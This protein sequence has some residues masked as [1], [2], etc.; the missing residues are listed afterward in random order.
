MAHNFE[1]LAKLLLN[2]WWI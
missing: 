2:G 1:L